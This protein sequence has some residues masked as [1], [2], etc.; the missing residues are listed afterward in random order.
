ML[1]QGI[2][3]QKTKQTNHQNQT[4]RGQSN[5]IDNLKEQIA[6]FY[7]ENHSFMYQ[8]RTWKAAY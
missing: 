6:T 4:Y 7:L 2:K 1:A 3:K 5:F 8:G